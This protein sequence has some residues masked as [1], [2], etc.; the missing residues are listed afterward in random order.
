MITIVCEKTMK[1]HVKLIS[2]SN[3]HQIGNWY[4]L[5]RPADNFFV[6]IRI[7]N[8]S[9]FARL[10]HN[11]WRPW[12]NNLP[13]KSH[14]SS[15]NCGPDADDKPDQRRLWNYKDY[16]W[17][18]H[19]IIDFVENIFCLR[20]KSGR[21]GKMYNIFF[22]FFFGFDWRVKSHSVEE[23]FAWPWPHTLEF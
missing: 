14:M 13:R 6:T 12:T 22:V 20:N 2:T 16:E 18:W 21:A 7:S 9:N 1:S 3:A 15:C 4:Q 10:Q 19:I 5:S 11:I 8:I 23:A 17:R